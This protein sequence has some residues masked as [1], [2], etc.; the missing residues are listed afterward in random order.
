MIM[1]LVSEDSEAGVLP[2][3]DYIQAMHDFN[4]ELVA[5]GA[6]LAAEGL[7]PSSK[8]ARIAYT[9]GKGR[10]V[11]GPFTES[12]E[13]I[14]GFWIIEVGSREEALDWALR[15]PVPC[16]AEGEGIEVR[17]VMDP[18]DLLRATE[19]RAVLPVLERGL[20]RMAAL[21]A[22]TDPARASAPTP[23]PEWDVAALVGHVIRQI[24]EFAG[25]E[26]VPAGDGWSAAFAASA[27]A[28]RAS[29]ADPD[30]LERVRATPAGTLDAR[31]S[32]SQQIVELAGHSWDLAVATGRPL[33]LDAETVELAHGFVTTNLKPEMRGTFMA[34]PVPVPERAAPQ[35]RFLGFIGRDPAWR[36]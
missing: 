5:A 11:D 4:A 33:E 20:D 17:R 3:D 26:P 34:E 18:A 24:A 27:D 6:L 30:A 29:W 10:V 25:A 35:D 36:G 13:L 15:I 12:K 32:I 31:W 22:E 21:I 2:D 1:G 28:L 23:C 16:D 8:G 14:A 9:Q 7:Y 19:A